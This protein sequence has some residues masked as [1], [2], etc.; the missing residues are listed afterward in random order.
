META[1]PKSRFLKSGSLLDWF[2]SFRPGNLIPMAAAGLQNL[3]LTLYLIQQLMASKKQRLEAL[4][5]LM[6]SAKADDWAL[7]RR[8]A[9]L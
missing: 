7:V 8:R 5:E 3:D 4:Q 6:P 9:V 1:T 2:C